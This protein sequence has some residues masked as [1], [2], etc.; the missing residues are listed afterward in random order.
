MNIICISFQNDLE[1]KNVGIFK[2][3]HKIN[4]KVKNNF[5]CHGYSE[6]RGKY[7]LMCFHSSCDL[8]NDIISSSLE[9]VDGMKIQWP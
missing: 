7:Q 3:S 2:W 5:P 9:T 1:K 6:S 8:G 4:N